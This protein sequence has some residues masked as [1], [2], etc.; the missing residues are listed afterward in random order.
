MTYDLD[1]AIF[2]Y[3]NS[4]A[5]A[6]FFWDWAILFRAAYLY[7]AVMLALVLFPL[8]TL[9]PRFQSRRTAHRTLFICA[10]GA[11]LISRLGITELIRL[12]YDRPRPFEVLSNIPQ[13]IP[14]PIGSSFP[15]GHVAFFFAIAAVVYAYYPKTGILF[16]VAAL[17]IG[18]GRVAAGVHWPSDIIAGAAAGLIGAVLARRV[19]AAYSTPPPP[20]RHGTEESKG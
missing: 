8:C 20:L 14:H 15:S 18:I 12:L 9:L 19:M 7:Y 2:R 16:F 3:L 5:G 4:W 17:S 10:L 6:S 11:A 1:I 13:L